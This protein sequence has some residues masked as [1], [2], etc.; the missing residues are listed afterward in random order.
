MKETAWRLF[1]TAKRWMELMDLF[2][3]QNR[4][5]AY[6]NIPLTLRK[7][8]QLDHIVPK[9]KGGE[10]VIDNLHWVHRTVNRMKSCMDEDS[11]LDLII[12]IADHVRD[13]R[14]R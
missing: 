12:K 5:C 7:N 9:S 6:S 1:G 8:A 14:K 4:R 11:F 10:N 3:K 13:R 2:D